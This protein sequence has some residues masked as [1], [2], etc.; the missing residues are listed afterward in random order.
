MHNTLLLVG[1]VIV[2]LVVLDVLAAKFGV[3]SRRN[4]SPRQRW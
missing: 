3:D 2:G 1:L 4:E